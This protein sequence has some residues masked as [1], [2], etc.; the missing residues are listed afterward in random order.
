MWCRRPRCA[1]RSSENPLSFLR[2]TR[3]EAEF[4]DDAMPDPVEVFERSRENLQEFIAKGVFFT[5]DEP[6]LY[7]YRLTA[8]EHVQTGIVACCSLDEYESGK[9]K[10]H[11]KTRPDKVKD[12]TDHLLAVRAQTG[13]ILL[14]YRGTSRID[15]LMAA[16][17]R[18][19]PIYDFCC[20]GGVQHT[21]WKVDAPGRT[22][23]MHLKAFRH[24]ILPTGIIV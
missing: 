5:E 21:F 13:L 14:A 23:R 16:A 18:D 9:I 6:S 12:R 2:I 10:K 1:G 7:V 8:G 15:Q 19:E 11:E 20:E 24:S 17:V 4:A 22:G 3:S